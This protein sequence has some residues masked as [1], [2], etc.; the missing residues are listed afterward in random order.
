MKQIEFLADDET[1]GARLD[2]AVPMLEPSLT[3]SAAQKLIENG[4]VTVNGAPVGKNYILKSGDKIDLVLPDPKA[5]EIK[6][7]R[8]DIDIVYEDDDILVV[9]KRK[10]MV[11]H[12]APGHYDDTLV[13][14]LLYHCGDSLSGINGEIRPGIVHRIDKDTSGLLMVAK[15]D[16]SHILLA[17]QI[18]AHTFKREY[19][20]VLV[21]NIKD[22]ISRIDRP[23]GRNPYD[24][25]KQAVGGINARDA[26][27]GIAVLKRYR[28]FCLVRCVLQ[29]G[30][31]HQIRVHTASI[32]HP[33][34]GDTVYGGEKN[35]FGL[36]GQCLHAGVLGFI[37]PS[38]G[39]YME[40]KAPLPRYFTDFLDKIKKSNW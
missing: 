22:D 32:G 1:G 14:A 37:H 29:T 12:P 2:R 6:P 7:V 11:V 36:R 23:I 8:L 28:Y 35:D 15:N 4:C 5:T 38:T 9:N 19:S 16:R 18:Q 10:G 13:N 20:A 25:K 33:V 17:E 39:R 27:T 21:G 26:V 24:R 31:T 34:A 30:R 40:F 3:R